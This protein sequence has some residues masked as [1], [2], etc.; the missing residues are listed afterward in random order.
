MKFLD[1]LTH[2]YATFAYGILLLLLCLAY[3]ITDGERAKRILGTVLTVLAVT[4]GLVYVYPPFDVTAKDSATGK[5]I[6]DPATGRVKIE[7]KG[8]IPLGID[9]KGGTTFLIRIQ[10]SEDP[11][12]GEKRA[13]TGESLDQ[14]VEV[15]R[16]RVDKM[17]TGEPVI[18]P[19]GG[20][21]VLV[22][23]PG[24]APE[25]LA[26]TRKQLQEVAKLDFRMVHPESSTL[27]PAIEAKQRILDPAWTVLSFKADKNP[28]A[29]ERKLL[30]HRV[31]DITGDH[32]KEAHAGY[33]LEGWF[34]SIQFD[35][36]AGN[37]FFELT[38]AMRVNQDR[39]AIV[40]DNKIISAPTTQVHGGI[41][42][43]SCR[44]TG[45]FTEQEARGLASSLLNPLQNP[46]EI[47]E[48]R[49]A[50][51]S[52]GADSIS[53]GIWSGV[54]GLL[55]IWIAVLY[56]YRLAGL[57]ALIALA[58]EGLL[59]FSILAMFGAV[60]TLPGIA[61]TV[62]TLGM[63]IDAN[64]LIYERLREEI[65]A[66][67]SLKAALD[68]SYSKAFSAIFDSHVTTLVTAAILYWQ[69]TGPV[70]GFAVTL[71]IG[72]VASMF[73]AL[74]ITRNLFL[75][76]FHFNILKKITMADLI[77][78]TN[79]NFLGQRRI[80]IGASVV[81]VV[82]LSVL[83]GMRGASN[84]GVDFRGG[85]RL[86][87]EA[88]GTKV[89]DSKVREALNELQLA[90]S[91]V[92][93]EKSA[94]AEFLTIRSPIDTSQKVDDHLKAKFPEAKFR[95]EATEKV[96]SAVGNELIRSSLIALGLGLLGI[97]LYVAVQFEV[98]F[99]ISALVAVI[100]DVAITIG[101]FSLTGHEIS[102]IFVGAVLTVAG[103]SVS[104]SIVVF[105][106]IREGI[107]N[108]ESGSITEI[109]NRSIN[110]TLS[111]TI[112][113][114]GTTL[115]ALAALY[116][117]GG[118]VLNDF[119]FTIFIGVVV[120]TFSSIYIAAPIVL[121]WSGRGGRNLRSEVKQ[122]SEKPVIPA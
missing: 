36:Q 4:I 33:D 92:Q 119:A 30:V 11:V 3:L 14:A 80:A 95:T 94:T 35:K 20:D 66:G 71:T 2:P 26:D 68:A 37:K 18:T 23:I 86:V 84:F 17:G 65:A 103:Y 91:V 56:Y 76:M 90:D 101:I 73:T 21:R 67:K 54:V 62:L 72:I 9:L 99:A 89:S 85:D 22:Q 50:S 15:I 52:L 57:V 58:I 49:S 82:V 42:G 74:V 45:K 78:K 43:G 8:R 61:G 114:G 97:M 117:L 105:D 7:K 40:L 70:K 107:R 93:T 122:K 10:P 32:I 29:T 104:D 47:A 108:G 16:S 110:D 27:L 100:H 39:F 64:V 46:V 19:S 53:S 44:I 113:T 69:A 102:L 120:G 87:L 1:F 25:Q 79:V 60:L 55:L 115:L 24:L 48:E 111:R 28:E 12:T 121:W 106:R 75:W 13:V 38:R 116:F 98:S 118:P 41:A 34:I 83:F 6:V 31:P 63:A 96:G 51:A 77:G 112:L 5:E 88:Q 59:L 81:L 109:M